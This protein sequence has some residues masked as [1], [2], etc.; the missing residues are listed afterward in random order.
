MGLD[1][2]EMVMAFEEAFALD[3]PN[4]AAERMRTVRDVIDYVFARKPVV[5]STTC[6]T[7][8]TF[9]VIRRA[10]GPVAGRGGRLTPD[11]RIEELSDRDSWPRLWER[12]RTEGG[13]A[14]PARVPW[15]SWWRDSPETLGELTLFV[16]AVRKT[17]RHAE[18]EPWT[19]DAVTATVRRVIYEQQ[20]IWKARLDDSFVE[21]FGLD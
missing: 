4:T 14:W 17:T 10:L 19:R 5:P 8:Q 6:S 20:G 18:G 21:D 2:V 7:Q 16:E 3:I 12:I 15:K 11:T 13:S 9:Y 1:T